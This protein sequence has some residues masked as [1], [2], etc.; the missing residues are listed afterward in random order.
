MILPNKL[1]WSTLTILLWSS[2]LSGTFSQSAPCTPSYFNISSDCQLLVNPKHI[3]T[4]CVDA[5]CAE[6]FP[7]PVFEKPCAATTLQ[8]QESQLYNLSCQ[9]E[10]WTAYFAPANWTVHKINGDGGVD[11]TGAPNALLV[12]GANKALVQIDP[13]NELQLQIVIPAEGY[14][15]FEWGNVGG[16]NLFLEVWVNG[17]LRSRKYAGPNPFFSPLLRTGDLVSL[18]FVEENYQPATASIRNF[19]FLTNTVGVLVR[20]WAIQIPKKSDLVFS[21]FIT[22]EKAKLTNII[23][24]ANQNGSGLKNEKDE[25]P[26]SPKKMGYPLIDWD[27]NPY[28]QEDQVPLDN[29]MYQLEMSWEDEFQKTDL[30]I[31][32][33][34]HWK[35]NDHCAG[36][37]VQETQIIKLY[38]HPELVPKDQRKNLLS[39]TAGGATVSID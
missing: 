14:I 35:I 3:S 37:Y 24:P 12:E 27:G 32:L 4:F 22:L 15:N 19:Q 8:L 26:I 20:K 9:Q 31:E 23:F 6:T 2:M 36:N 5:S 21:Q 7:V 1:Y 34:R 11:V 25:T 30:G 39:G 18:R 16:S 38:D 13:L 33:L 17:Q 10:G 28:T 29:N